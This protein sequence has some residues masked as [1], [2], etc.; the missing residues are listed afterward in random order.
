MLLAAATL[1][2]Q[3]APDRSKAPAPGPPPVMKLPP[4]QKRTLANGLPVWIVEM[5]EVP[6]ADITVIVKAGA[7]ADPTGKFGLADFTAAM[8]DEGAGSRDSLAIADAVD[9]LGASL[10]TGSSYDA[11][12]I[13]LHTPVSKL[14]DALQIL[15]DVVLRPTFSES[16]LE[17]LRKERLTV[18]LQMRDQPA[19][20]ASAAFA[21]VVFGPRHRYGTPRLGNDASNSEM[22][23][24]DL[25][26]FYSAY[27]QPQ[28]A[29][30]L[31]V[32]DVTADSVLPKL[33]RALGAW[34]NAGALPK[35]AVPAAS[36]HPARQIYLVDK[37]NAAQSEI[38]IGGVGVARNTP[39]YFVLDVLNT[40]LGGSFTSRLNQ[41]L[42]EQHGYAYGAGSRF[43]MRASNG[44]FV[45]SAAVQTD[46]TVESLREM[47]KELDD[48]HKP[49]SPDEL[50]KAR[51]LEALGFPAGFETTMGMAGNLAELVIYSLP[52]SFFNEYVPTIQAVTA[53][54][55]ERASRQYLLTDKFAVVVV[56]DLA[57][58][59]KP[60]RD[61][62]FGPV[63]VVKVDEVLK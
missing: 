16:E 62:N 49:V 39:D 37:P 41:N 28:G 26:G 8:L 12:T 47:F 55:A 56:G 45:A 43:D 15:S 25:K 20:L 10:S 29:H 27:Y 23:A 9:F 33:E 24:S 5:H 54:D 61:A 36:Q 51:N 35:V 60:I 48:I 46:K 7:G 52:E 3:Q 44:P 63:K 2:A 21:R 13:R 38:R 58:I 34:K 50:G 31:V 18:L 59:E 14:D 4:I 32:G 11:S 57:K 40:I 6:V 19:S 17:R 53:S 22:S 42:R 1:A 30:V